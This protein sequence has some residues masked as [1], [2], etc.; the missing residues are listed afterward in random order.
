MVSVNLLASL[1]K[2]SYSISLMSVLLAQLVEQSHPI[3]EVS[4]SNPVI[5]TIYVEHLFTMNLL[6]NTKI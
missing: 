6:E 3:P 1:V 4:G 5:G 2:V